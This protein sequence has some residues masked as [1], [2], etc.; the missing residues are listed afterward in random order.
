MNIAVCVH[1]YYKEMFEEIS[2]Y[3]DNFGSIKF[4]LYFTLPKENESFLPI[5]KKKYPK[6]KYIVTENIGF[7]IYPFLC[8]IK[9]I[10][11]NYY[12]VI[13]KLHS[14][15]DIPIKYFKNGFDLSGSKWRDYM[16]KALLSSNTQINYVLKIIERHKHIG[17]ICAKEVFIKGER[18]ISMDIDLKKV[19]VTML[20]CKLLVRN[21]EFAA[22]SIFAIR[23]KLL[24]PLLKRN[25][26]SFEFPDY[27]PRDW[28]SLPYC[29][30]RVFGC[31]ISSQGMV[32]GDI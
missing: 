25:F 27:Y 24:F 22:G 26:M 6:C 20:E 1:L 8:F 11:L 19:E 2:Y 21:W 13:F 10:N 29:I 4:D 17:M 32:I 5:I 9:E 30:E 15:R 31:M 28:N 14:K 23:P 12:D 18:E 16:F 3:L 7:D